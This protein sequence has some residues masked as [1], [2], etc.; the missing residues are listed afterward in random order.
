MNTHDNHR[1]KKRR[2]AGFLEQQRTSTTHA[3]VS[4]KEEVPGSSPGRPTYNT[5]AKGGILQAR[6]EGRDKLPGP[7]YCNRSATRTGPGSRDGPQRRFHRV[8][9]GVLHVGQDVGVGV[10]GE[11]MEAWPSISETTFA[12]TPS[13]KSSVA[14]V[15]L[16]A[17]CRV[18]DPSDIL[19]G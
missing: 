12:L 8:D 9:C 16:T 14:Q 7:I 6:R 15:C 17:G 1:K 19:G 18:P 3:L 10:E 5:P 4:D 2:F 11:V 13:L